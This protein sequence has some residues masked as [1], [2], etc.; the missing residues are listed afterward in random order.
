MLI[1]VMV[2]AVIEA[3]NL[4]HF[5]QFSDLLTEFISFASKIVMGLV[6]FGLGLFL[7]SWI[8]GVI[9]SSNK[10]RSVFFA[11]IARISIIILTG[12]MALRQ[13][14]IADDIINMAFGLTLGALAVATAI[15]F[16]IGGRDYAASQINKWSQKMN[17]K[18]NS[19]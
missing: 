19:N 14:G 8:A 4:L 9:E 13:M 10:P 3:A 18:D 1:F 6:I 15:A 12:A 17:S 5:T 7:A 11:L 16:G 2:F